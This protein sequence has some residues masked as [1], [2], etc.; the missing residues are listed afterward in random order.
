MAAVAEHRSEKPCWVTLL[1][2]ASYLP[3]VIIL[4]HTL[5]KHRSQYPLIV[6]YTSS[7]GDEAIAALT[8][9]GE[10][11][12]RIVPMYV[13]LLL[14]RSGQ[15]NTGSVAERFNDTFTKLRAFQVYHLGYTQAAF[16]DAD[17]AVFRNPD[18][19]FEIELPGREW[20]GA[21]HS[22]V[23][24][25]DKDA[26]APQE[27][28]KHH[29]ACTPLRG[30]LEVA[31]TP[32]PTDRQTYRSLN[33]GLFI[34]H[35]TEKLWERLIEFFNTTDKLKTYQFPDQDFL[36]DFF[37]DRWQPVSWKYNA[38]KTMRYWHPRLWS[39]DELVVLHYIVDKPWERQVSDKG[40]AGHLGRDGVTHRWWWDIYQAWTQARSN[41]SKDV[42]ISKAMRK[43]VGQEEP[44]TETVPLPQKPGKPEDAEP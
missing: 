25:L 11:H 31:P 43:L 34:F 22:C 21:N 13:D 35:P 14:P 26:W 39:D 7:L 18:E 29:C 40:V 32:K 23:C 17:M 27:W 44:F 38:L 19:L 30:P 33:G 1:T 6:Q 2:K 37:N 8:A 42:A 41:S 12:G 9:E 10:N 24:N 4:A 20:L 15:E 3:G 5:D 16:L 36:A 28:T